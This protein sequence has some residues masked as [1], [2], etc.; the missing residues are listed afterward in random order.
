MH[1]TFEREVILVIYYFQKIRVLLEAAQFLLRSIYKYFLWESAVK[2][3][4][5]RVSRAIS[6]FFLR[7]VTLRFL[8]YF[9]YQKKTDRD[10][11]LVRYKY[12]HFIIL[13]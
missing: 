13:R 9:I 12:S 1:K 10:Q 2:L 5:E 7:M 11:F 6:V 3:Y 4:L 8:I